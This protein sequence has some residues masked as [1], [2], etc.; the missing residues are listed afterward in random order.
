M[1]TLARK[2]R[3]AFPEMPDWFEN[4]PARFAMPTM[5]DLYTVR[6]E[7]YTQDGRYVMRAELPG[8]APEDIDVFISDG[9][10]T[11]QAERSE[12]DITKSHSE[13]RYGSMSRSVSLPPGA[14][15]DDVKADY[16]D[17]MLTVSVGLGTQKQEAKHV[18]IQ[19]GN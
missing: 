19:H 12:Q 10:L 5:G 14:D 6:I 13:I 15:E 1:T 11:V 7:D 16:T 18:E 9:V 8:M 2:Q 17:G 4:L 3:F